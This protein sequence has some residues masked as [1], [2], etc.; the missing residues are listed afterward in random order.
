[1]SW[2]D[3]WERSQNM[4]WA[5]VLSEILREHKLF[6][7]WM[8]ITRRL[9]WGFLKVCRERERVFDKRH[10]VCE[11]QPKYHICFQRNPQKLIDWHLF[12]IHAVSSDLSLINSIRLF[13]GYSFITKQPFITNVV[14]WKGKCATQQ[15]HY[16]GK[17]SAKQK[18][19]ICFHIENSQTSEKKKK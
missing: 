2:E 14:N 12:L 19:G 15:K 11:C 17:R 9:F 8:T 7:G 13:P 10:N 4:S 5:K 18:H 3:P 16:Q 6:N 1:M